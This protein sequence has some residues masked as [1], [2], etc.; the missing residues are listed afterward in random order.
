[1]LEE[2][3]I[4]KVNLKNVKCKSSDFESKVPHQLLLRSDRLDRDEW[5]TNQWK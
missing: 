1:M 2:K 5:F 3:N 4:L